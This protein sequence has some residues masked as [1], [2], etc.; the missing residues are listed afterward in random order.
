LYAGVL[1]TLKQRNVI[2]QAVQVAIAVQLLLI[3]SISECRLIFQ[4][5]KGEI[6]VH[7]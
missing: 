5:G 1:L 3:V 7:V 4:P 6:K 2:S